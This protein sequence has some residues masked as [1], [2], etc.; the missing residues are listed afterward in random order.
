M[1]KRTWSTNKNQ[2]TSRNGLVGERPT[3]DKPSHIILVNLYHEIKCIDLRPI[4]ITY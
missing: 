3:P 1:G 2:A 4:L